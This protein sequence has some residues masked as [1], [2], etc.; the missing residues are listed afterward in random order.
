[1]RWT[2]YLLPA[3]TAAQCHLLS[4]LPPPSHLSGTPDLPCSCPDSSAAPLS[5]RPSIIWGSF[6]QLL[7]P[8]A[9]LDHWLPHFHVLDGQM[10]ERV[11][12]RDALLF[13]HWPSPVLPRDHLGL[14][15]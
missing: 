4:G 14:A 1:M 9:G 3:I 12:T 2:T 6:V 7:P 15:D 8:P 10:D 5:T 11:D 13:V